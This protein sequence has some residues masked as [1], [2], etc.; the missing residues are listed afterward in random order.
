MSAGN[1]GDSSFLGTG[2]GFPPAFDKRKKSVDMLSGEEDIMS[3]LQILMTTSLGERVLRS[4]FGSKVPNMIFETIDSSQRAI[5]RQHIIDAIYLYEPRIVPLDVI[6]EMD[7]L[8]GRVDIDVQF[9]IVA[10]NNRR[11]FVYP[12]Y[13]LEGTE[14][15]K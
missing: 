13:V 7:V 8:E 11:N 5:L 2:W 10:T 3:S 4:K 14:V 9:K 15:T 1:I 12:F 6:V